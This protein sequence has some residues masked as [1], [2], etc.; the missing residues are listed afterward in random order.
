M[1]FSLDEIRYQTRFVLQLESRDTPKRL[2]SAVMM[3]GVCAYAGLQQ[4]ALW[5]GAV[6][7]LIEL[8]AY[9]A[10]RYLPVLDRDMS[11]RYIAWI[12]V[13][14]SISVMAYLSPSYFLAQHPSTAMLLAAMMW[15]FG[16]IVHISNSF[17]A[18]PL[19]NWTLMVPSLGMTVALIVKAGQS[20]YAP[21]TPG[22]WIVTV[23]LLGVYG[24]NTYETLTKQKDTQAAL[25]LARQE[26]TVRLKALEYVSRHDNLTGLLNRAAFDEELGR[27]LSDK[28][29]A[30][31][32]AVYIID[33]DGFKPI[34]DSYGH[35]AGDAVLRTVA[36]RLRVLMQ[37]QGLLARL[38]GDEFAI[39][40]P[41]REAEGVV[42]RMAGLLT[43]EIE[44]PIDWQNKSLR[45]AAS[46]GVAVTRLAGRSVEALCGGADRAMYRAKAESDV[47]A[48]LFDPAQYDR[49]P[50]LEDRQRII[51]AFRNGDI[52]PHYQPKVVLGTLQ[53]CGFEALARW[54]NPDGTILPPAQFIPRINELGLQG[55][56][57]AHM[58]QQV[59]RDVQD[60]VDQGL[61][62]GE[63]SV[64]LPEIALATHTGREELDQLLAR[65]PRARP[66]ITLEITEDVFIA[67]A[68]DMIQNSIAHFRRAG[69]RI[70][71]DDFGTGFASFQH[72]RQLDFDE[73]KI[74]ASFV[75]DLAH[76]RSA[77]I[78]VAGFLSMAAG[79][80]VA[81]IAEGIETTQQLAFLRRTGCLVGQGFLFGHALPLEET[82]VRLMTEQSG[83]A[84][85]SGAA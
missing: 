77:R 36:D 4:P 61:D 3:L 15:T 63:V 59:L 79:L 68:A 81:V 70:S 27:M 18:L 10:R 71:L 38:G 74:D 13:Q 60:M 8:L 5:V 64:N 69:Q 42:M 17:A 66:H 28:P 25:D 33:L 40:I 34:N 44:L 11:A 73:L 82:K 45:I 58:T 14:N 51:D 80:G 31:P 47:K 48:L 6:I 75:A 21:S 46:I 30:Q 7:A 53:T 9:H 20:T 2:A 55:E 54:V 19:Y 49:T 12:W 85:G 78:L 72:L 76:D 41:G 26:A 43:Q 22:E 1:K 24:A 84:L 35:S 67:R 29:L 83:G 37:G 23:A 50:S 62:P 32:V 39:A 56:F 16:V 52:R 57:L 65:Y